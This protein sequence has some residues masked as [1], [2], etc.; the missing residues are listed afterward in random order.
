MRTRILELWALAS[1]LNLESDL[2]GS[3]TFSRIRIREKIIPDLDP[4]GS[5]SE[6]NLKTNYSENSRIQGQKD[7][8]SRIRIRISKNSS[9]L[10]EKIV[11]KLSE[12]CSGWFIPDPDLIFTHPGSLIQGVKKAPD[13]GS[14]TLIFIAKCLQYFAFL[15]PFVLCRHCYF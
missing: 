8:W 1:V 14:A 3:E 13:P 15:L 2:V 12:I 6:M 5:G 9:I 11:S 10:T 7:S 4:G